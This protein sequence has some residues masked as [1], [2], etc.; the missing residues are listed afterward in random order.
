M[1][2]FDF[3]NGC[4]SMLQA[5]RQQR[6]LALI[7]QR[8]I[9]NA[10]ELS[11]ELN[12]SL[13]TIRRDL[14]ELEA[15]S[16]L[17]RTHGG[18]VSNAYSLSVEQSVN[19]KR[20]SYADEKKRI[21]QAAAAL[22]KPGDTII[23]DSSTTV[24]AITTFLTDIANL[25]VITNDLLNVNRLS[26]CGNISLMTV[27][28]LLRKGSYTHIGYFCERM[29][30]EIHADIAFLGVDA[31]NSKAGAMICAQEGT[32]QKRLMV[33]AAAQSVIVCDHSKFTAKALVSFCGIRSIS[34]IITGREA[35][36]NVA[37]LTEIRNQGVEVVTV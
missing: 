11:K 7:E 22:V 9:V 30:E 19:V 20:D 1:W 12:A 13:S 17:T 31:V 32:R 6:I 37:V 24:N 16:K 33:E 34:K 3:T 5:E 23:L 26:Q 14:F 27:G 29:L 15:N 28:G 10:H 4:D 21:A 25:T 18:A 8:G 2:Q 36:E 35:L